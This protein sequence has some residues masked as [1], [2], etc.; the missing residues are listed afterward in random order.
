MGDAPFSLGEC[1]KDT[2]EWFRVRKKRIAEFF[3][4]PDLDKAENKRVCLL[5][6]ESGATKRKCCNSLYCDHCYTKNQTCPYCKTSTRQEKMTG[7]TFAVQ[8][9]SEHEECRCCLEPG[10]KRRCCGSYYCDD[11]YYKLP[12]CRGC[13]APTGNKP[14]ISAQWRGSALA[15]LVS[16]LTT[17][18]VI[19]AIVVFVLLYSSSESQVKV[20]MSGYQCYGWWK[21]C[22]VDKCLDMP[23][24]TSLGYDP[25]PPLAS[26]R[27]CDYKNSMAKLITKACV[28]DQRLYDSTAG[29]LGYDLCMDMFQGGLYV[30]E[31]TFEHYRNAS[32]HS[33]QM[34]SGLWS[35]ITNGFS[36]PYCGAATEL[37]GQRSLQFSGENTREAITKD[38]NIDSGGWLEAELFIA[39]IGFDVTNPKC[40]SAYSGVIHV[41]YSID[42]GKSWITV[43]IYNAWEYRQATFFPI[44]FVFPRNSKGATKHTRFRFHQL[45]FEGARDAWA[46]DNVRVLRFLPDDWYVLDLMQEYIKKTQSII[47]RAQC[48]FDTDWCETRLTLS[49]M[50][51][52]GTF[53]EW[54]NGRHY[55]IRG[56]ELYIMITLVIT[57]FKW[58]YLCC[59]DWFLFKRLPLQD[60]WEDLTKI[61]RIMQYIP[62][63][64]RP[65]KN[66]ASLV[67][68]I[69]TSARLA[70]ELQDAF[71]DDEGEGEVIKTK[72]DLEAEK[73]EKQAALKKQK[74]LLKERMKNRNFKG[75]ASLNVVAAEEPDSD[76][77]KD[78]DEG[79]LD[80]LFGAAKDKPKSSGSEE[81]AEFKKTNVGMLRVPF[82]TKVN[83][84]WTLF[85]RNT[86]LLLFVA[87]AMFKMSTT[88]YY[89]V[90]EP[91]VAFG[92]YEGDMSVTSAGVFLFA[93]FL[94]L[95]EIYFCLKKVVP[96]RPEWV[97]LITL[98]LQEDVSSLFI[99]PH[100]IKL[101]DISEFTAFSDTFA[102]CL[103]LCYFL[104]AF[105]WCLFSVIL[106]DQFLNFHTMRVASPILGLLMGFRAILGPGLFIKFGFS[107]YY[108]FAFDPKTR[109]RFGAALT[110]ER[111]SLTVFWTMV[112]FAFIGYVVSGIAMYEYANLIAQLMLPVG[113][114][115]GAFTGCIHSLP[116]H[117]WMYLT[118]VRGGVWM[119]V[120]KK[121]RCPCIY[122]GSF[123]TTMH[124]VDE[125]FI[126]W[127]DDQVKFLNY[128]KG[129]VNSSA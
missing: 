29:Y 70:A 99:G 120:K 33:N 28:Y 44:K 41:D 24:S 94:D 21:T 89:V 86:M 19:S 34:K 50:D 15:V 55:F 17:I 91:Y 7:A 103:A 60:E 39:P 73:K 9:F 87:A 6:F 75:S 92:K 121:Q 40:K 45:A 110:T 10:L 72:E 38:V 35:N 30:M 66:I 126:V 37:G 95:K 65:K 20:L 76:E 31:D 16:W 123:C 84:N 101:S 69:H 78:G 80:A 13:D 52:C 127:S 62:K 104:G 25:L 68:N 54:Y 83:W 88:S 82:N 67:G 42:H 112:S 129:G 61:D 122:W 109:E 115:Y 85:F 64:Y 12:Q 53:F 51:E 125:I 49:E 81:L 46:L 18:F 106:R 57:V 96:C 116:I 98:D 114:V 2:A 26:W 3:N 32:W 1:L 119:K 48:C 102:V 47:Q 4:P 108:L 107:L 36:T 79:R 128:L 22:T 23:V 56:A 113:F 74:K 111:T 97:P 63:R 11:C 59:V 58:L 105:P 27:N 43:G 118:I 90:H 100:V 14:R 124:E 5:C 71:K 117:P 8:Q 77:E 93:A